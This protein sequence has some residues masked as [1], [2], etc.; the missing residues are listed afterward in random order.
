ML[1]K[2]INW[3]LIFGLVS[4]R[5]SAQTNLAI[6]H[7]SGRVEIIQGNNS[8]IAVRGDAIAKS[9]S[10]LLRE[11]ADCMLIGANGKSLQL[12]SAG[13]YS[14]EKLQQLIIK[15]GVTNVSQRYF[16]YVYDNLFNVPK[17]DKLSVSPVVFRDEVLMKEPVNYSIV[18]STHF[19]FSWKK[20]VDKNSV[21]IIIRNEDVA[22]F[23][24]VFKNA[25]TAVID[26]SKLRHHGILYQWR[27]E[28]AGAKQHPDA[29]NE[30]LIPMKKDW[31]DVR[32]EQK[33]V[34]SNTLNKALKKQMQLDLFEKWKRSTGSL[35][36]VG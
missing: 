14:Y 26:L 12:N 22:I 33:L 29:W 19:L 36:P 17:A 35:N 25:T 11:G 18:L 16:K 9:N 13:S 31:K 3:I 30:F 32:A 23:D 24:S 7:T 2:I 20:P 4:I 15:A 6:Y 8:K 34:H 27:A 10:L 28:E 21:R 1:I 5:I